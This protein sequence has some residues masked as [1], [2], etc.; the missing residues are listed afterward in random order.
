MP[1]SIPETYKGYGPWRYPFTRNGPLRVA[2]IFL[3]EQAAR[4]SPQDDLFVGDVA[5]QEIRLMAI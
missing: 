1:S 3:N 5:R 4:F 2:P